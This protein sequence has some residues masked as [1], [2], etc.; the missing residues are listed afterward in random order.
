[1]SVKENQKRYDAAR[2]VSG[3]GDSYETA[4]LIA[5]GKDYT[6]ATACEDGF[7]ANAWGVKDKDWRLLEKT[8]V[9]ENGRTYDMVQ[10]E[11]PKV[12]EKHFY[13]FDITHYKRKQK[14]SRNAEES[15]QVEKSTPKGSGEVS[16]ASPAVQPDTKK[17]SVAAP[18]KRDSATA[19][20]VVTPPTQPAAASAATPDTTKAQ[21]AK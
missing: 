19:P 1:M 15:E 20:Q 4:V 2:V 21:P 7:I 17:E 16:H 12:G 13:Y 9:V 6:D 18:S 14:S 5:G 3:N 8:P 10:V 11:I